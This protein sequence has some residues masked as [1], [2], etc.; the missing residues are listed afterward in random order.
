MQGVPEKKLFYVYRHKRIFP[1][2]SDMIPLENL[3]GY[4][5]STFKFLRPVGA[6]ETF[7]EIQLLLLVPTPVLLFLH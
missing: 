6:H 4:D 5:F 7:T 2:T 3:F 1:A